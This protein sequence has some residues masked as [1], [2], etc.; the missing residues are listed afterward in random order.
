MVIPDRA[1]AF[2]RL[3]VL[4]DLKPT[5]NLWKDQI[6]DSQPARP[7]PWSSW[8]SSS[9]SSLRWPFLEKSQKAGSRAIIDHRHP[10]P[11][12]RARHLLVHWTPDDRL[13][14][15]NGPAIDNTQQI[16]KGGMPMR[17][18]IKFGLLPD[19]CGASLGMGIGRHSYSSQNERRVNVLSGRQSL[20]IPQPVTRGRFYL[21]TLLSSIAVI[22]NLTKSTINLDSCSL[23]SIELSSAAG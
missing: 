15:P 8:S 18:D 23:N 3:I 1:I 4:I 10:C 19:I 22:I 21:A 6:T 13:S 16:P 20:G 12:A 5:G 17:R 2:A 9:P 14:K 11:R 7:S